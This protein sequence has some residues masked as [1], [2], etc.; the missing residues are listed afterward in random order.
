[1]PFNLNTFSRDLSAFVANMYLNVLVAN[2]LPKRLSNVTR[3]DTTLL[4]AREKNY[5]LTFKALSS[6][7]KRI[8][9]SPYRCRRLCKVVYRLAG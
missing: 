4:V 8:F 2:V 9:F 6:P 7:Q 5:V 3:M 1:M